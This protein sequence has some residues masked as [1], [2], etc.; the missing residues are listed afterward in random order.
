MA[1]LGFA[2]LF[3]LGIA[4]SDLVFYWTLM[5]GALALVLD[6]ARSPVKLTAGLLALTNATCLLVYTLTP[7]L[8]GAALLGL[9]SATRLGTALVLGYGWLLLVRHFGELNLDPLFTARQE[10]STELAVP[11]AQTLID[12]TPHANGSATPDE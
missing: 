12:D 7:A 1:G 3:P 6:G 2:F 4:E 9:M 5:A 8:P 10:Y 11:Q